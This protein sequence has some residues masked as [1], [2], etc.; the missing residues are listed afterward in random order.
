MKISICDDEREFRTALKKIIEREME[1]EGIACETTE[2]KSGEE[3]IRSLSSKEPDIL[4][5]DIEMGNMNGMDTAKELRKRCRSTIIIFVTAYPDFVFQGYEVHALH[6][7]L[8]PY[9]EEKIKEVLHMA[10]EELKMSEDQYYV[11]EQKSTAIK[12]PLK[13]VLYFQSDR[14][15]VKAVTLNRTEEFYDK[16]SDMEAKLPAYFVR[17]H[18]RYLVNLNYV[19][20]VETSVCICKGEE[21]PVSRGCRQELMAAFARMMLR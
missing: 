18:N 15:K 2:Y 7:I 19:E 17:C 10:L 20:R 4:F 3:F 13:S 1:L 12:L 21:I 5:L 8:K 16:L 6:Y 14:K 9:K 11:I